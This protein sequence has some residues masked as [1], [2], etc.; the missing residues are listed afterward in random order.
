VDELENAFERAQPSHLFHLA[1]H[2]EA[3][4][5]PQSILPMIDANVYFGCRLAEACRIVPDC[6]FVNVE[7]F[8]QHTSSNSEL[9]SLYA[10]TKSL[11]SRIGN[12]YRINRG[13]DFRSL[14]V[15]DTFGLGDTRQKLLSRVIAAGVRNESLAL[16]EGLQLI[17]LVH[18][19]DVSVALETLGGLTAGSAERFWCTS[20]RPMTI[21]EVV[22]TVENVLS[23]QIKVEWGSLPYRGTEVFEPWPTDPIVPNW[24]PT[25]SLEQGI[26]TIADSLT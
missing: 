1:T 19:D 23:I 26:Q 5:N 17:D 12:F 16:S 2:F 8:W 4:H 21:R 24:H 13:L 25:V 11:F 6:A 22:D 10:L 7:S 14:V 20:S 15:P 9:L 3:V 18:V